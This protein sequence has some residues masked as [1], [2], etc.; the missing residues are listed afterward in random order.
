MSQ[1]PE[2]F[3]IA[4]LPPYPLGG[5]AYAVRDA[6][7]AG[8]DIVDLSQ[9]NPDLGPPPR[10]IDALV[11]AA[12]QPHNHR[13][14][15]SQGIA[16]LRQAVASWYQSH[17]DVELDPD[18]EVVATMGTKEG[19][20]HLL[21][22]AAAPG[23]NV[24]VPTPSYPIHTS[25]VFIAGAG[26]TGVPLFES[27]TAAEA[28]GYLLQEDSDDFF[29]RLT[30][31][32]NRAWP[33]P[34]LLI[35]SFPHNPT[36]AVVDQGFFTRLVH[37]AREHEVW[38]VHDFAYADLVYD[39]YRAPSLLA[40]PGAKECAVECY[41]L[42]KG[43]SMPGWRIGFCLGNPRLLSALKKVKSYLDF[44]IFQPMQIAATKLLEDTSGANE[45][46]A[47]HRDTYRARRDVLVEGLRELG[48]TVHTPAAGVFVWAGLPAAV[49]SLGSLAFS[50]R[51]LA[52]ASVAVCPGIGFAIDAD[53]YVRFALVENERRLRTALTRMAEVC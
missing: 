28:A 26:F 40:V 1:P 30:L 34:R 38:L 19:L 42:S 44:G 53:G 7:L 16:R 35:C 10:A 31:A 20:S 15:S 45:L 50:E 36:A 22:A 3:R 12:L 23:E 13:Y 48:W 47:E 41:S 14:S 37:W 9:V 8:R 49:A 52:E 4:H 17:Y 32:Y 21:L 33:R 2:F 18:T 43:F 24:L 27:F 5:I 11:Q 25:A 6:R 39:N 51:L 29:D 46:L